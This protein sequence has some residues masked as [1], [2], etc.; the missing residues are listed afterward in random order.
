M[1]EARGMAFGKAVAAEALDLLEAAFG[2]VAVIA[3]RRHA[4]DHLLAER[5]DG[6][7]IAERR[8]GAAQAVGLFR[9]ELRRHDGELHRL[10]LEQRHA[11]R[12]AQHLF[13]FVGRT[14]LGRRRGEDDRLLP[15]APAQIGMHHVALDRARAHD[16]DLD[17]E[18]VEFARPQARQHVHLRA[19]FDLEHADGVGLAQHVVDGGVFARHG[20]EIEV[21]AFMHARSGRTPCGCRSACRAPAHRPS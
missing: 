10:F 19:A 6:A 8:H 18:I 15:A 5:V 13:Q 4:A 9:R 12:L 2:E 14:V 16:R 11:Q 17:D 20:G 7:D 21:R 3:A 1:R